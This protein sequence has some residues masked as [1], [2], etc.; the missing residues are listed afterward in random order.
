M[1]NGSVARKRY[2][3]GLERFNDRLKISLCYSGISLEQFVIKLAPY[4]NCTEVEIS[5]WLR[6]VKCPLS[7]QIP[8][9][10]MILNV[11]IVWLQ[12]GLGDMRCS[13]T[14]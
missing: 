7:A 8:R 13:V 12:T 6:G 5:E 4:C 9:I 10:A 14:P 2:D 11:K 1:L 3:R